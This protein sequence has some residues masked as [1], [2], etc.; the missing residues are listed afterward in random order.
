MSRL[1]INNPFTFTA[2]KP[3]TFRP[4]ILKPLIQSPQIHNLHATAPHRKIKPKMEPKPFNTEN[5]TAAVG[6][7]SQACVAGDTIYVSGEKEQPKLRVRKDLSA[8]STYR[9]TPG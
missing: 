1:L 3:Q 8:D 6:P 7:Y 9:P 5:A 4:L 2:I